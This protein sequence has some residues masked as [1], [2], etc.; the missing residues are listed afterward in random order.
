MRS[1]ALFA[2]EDRGAEADAHPRHVALLPF[3]IRHGPAVLHDGLAR[4]GFLRQLVHRGGQSILFAK[5]VPL[6]SK[7]SHEELLFTRI[8]QRMSTASGVSDQNLQSMCRFHKKKL[9]W[10]A[11][12]Q[13]GS[14]IC[15][16]RI[17]FSLRVVQFMRVT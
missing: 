1:P 9:A 3:S 14:R 5:R 15:E 10:E 2:V 17:D 11:W 6:R 8:F 12:S 13:L 7:C 4:G 16:R